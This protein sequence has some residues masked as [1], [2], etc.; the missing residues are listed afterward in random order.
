MGGWWE[1]EQGGGN[2][3]A[4]VKGGRVEE[5]RVERTGPG[6]LTACLLAC[7]HMK[8]ERPALS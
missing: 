8:P 7:W 4:G 1:R 3:G 6:W 2:G 5:T